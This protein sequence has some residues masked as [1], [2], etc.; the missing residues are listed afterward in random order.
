[1]IGLPTVSQYFLYS[2]PTEMRKSFAGLSGLVN[3]ELNKDLTAGDGF[4]FINKRRTLMK[5]LVWDRTGFVIYYKKLVRGTFELPDQQERS[6]HSS[7]TLS[8]LL[9]MLEGIELKSVQFR[10][11]YD[12]SHK[13]LRA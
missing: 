12:R 6:N 1:M 5:I 11:R 13:E 8:T 4:V 9:L 7:L 2:E 3:N 10:K